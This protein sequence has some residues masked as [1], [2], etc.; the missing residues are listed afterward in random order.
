LG[1]GSY[2]NKVAD[3]NHQYQSRW[4]KAYI[5]VCIKGVLCIFVMKTCFKRIQYK[6]SRRQSMYQN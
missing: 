5:C 1:G 6:E 2:E 4:V 3:E